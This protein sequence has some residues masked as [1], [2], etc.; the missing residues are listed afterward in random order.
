M[1]ET[2]EICIAWV[3]TLKKLV[4]AKNVV[5]SGSSVQRQKTSVASIAAPGANHSAGSMPNYVN[6]HNS[7]ANNA[8]SPRSST[9][10]MSGSRS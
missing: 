4:S 7:S 3:K 10:P 8:H 1:T 5:R 9:L 2:E 6:Y